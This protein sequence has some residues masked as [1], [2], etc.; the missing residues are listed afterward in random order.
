VTLLFTDIEGSTPLVRSLGG[1]YAD[2]LADHHRLLRDAFAAH[3]GY[4]VDTQ[5]DAFFVAFARASDAIDAATMA[6]Q[7][8]AAHHWPAGGIVRVRM[9]LH[10]GQPQ[11]TDGRYVGLDVHR[12]ARIAAA[13]HGG[14]VL[15]S[16]A[17]AALVR[18]TLDES[19]SLQNLGEH[20]FKHFERPEAVFQLVISGLPSE[21]PA[22]RGI[23]SLT[24]DHATPGN[25]HVTALVGRN[26]EQELLLGKLTQAVGGHGGLV[27]L[28]GEPGIGKTRLVEALG[29]EARKRSVQVLWGRCWES[30]GAPPFWPWVEILRGVVHSR[31]PLVFRAELGTGGPLIT[32]LVPEIGMQLPDQPPTPH[33]SAGEDRFRL[34]DAVTTLLQNV[35]RSQPL[36]VALDDLHWADTSSLLLLQFLA[37]RLGEA[38]ILV[39][40]TH[41]DAEVDTEHSLKEVLPALR[42]ERTFESIALTGLDI[43]AVGALITGSTNEPATIGTGLTEALWRQTNG[44]P[45]F[46]LEELRFLLE[47]GRLPAAAADRGSWSITSLGLPEG[48][49]D[50]IRQRLARLSEATADLLGIAA[51]IG[52][53]FEAAPLEWSSGAGERAVD[54]ALDEAEATRILEILPTELGRYRFAH[55]LF[56]EALYAELPARRRIRLHRRVGESLERQYARDPEAHL[57][58][59]AYHFVQALPTGTA[60][61]A[62]AYSERAAE[63][64]MESYAFE[65]A[66]R[67]FEQALRVQDVLDAADKTKRC[68]LV[69]ALGGALLASNEPRPVFDRIAPE[70]LE[71]ADAIGERGRATRSCLLALSGLLRYG[72]IPIT[73]TRP[74]RHWVEL[75]DR[76]AVNGTV[77]R[78]RVDL[79]SALVAVASGQVDRAVDLIRRSYELALGLAEP[80]VLALA[81]MRMLNMIYIAPPGR[82]EEVELRKIADQFLTSAPVGGVSV[83]S[84][85]LEALANAYRELGD[86]ERFHTALEQLAQLSER[87]KAPVAVNHVKGNKM[88]SALVAGDLEGAAATAARLRGSP[89]APSLPAMVETAVVFG[90]RT[91]LHLGRIE[92]L[93]ELVPMGRQLVDAD[94]GL[95]QSAMIAR[96]RLALLSALRGDR[97][98]AQQRLDQM[99]ADLLK[100]R[101]QPAA[102]V[103]LTLLETALEVQ[104]REAVKALAERLAPDAWRASVGEALT[105]AAR[106][107]GA[108]AAFLGEQDQARAYYEEALEV[109]GRLRFRPELALTH[110]QLAEL[111]LDEPRGHDEAMRHLNFAIA[112]FRDM[113]MQPSLERALRH[114]DVLKA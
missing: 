8:L 67:H 23:H 113:K 104:D 24:E 33:V 99:V 94:E 29:E 102:P 54:E 15:L 52:R 55:A 17:T 58:E 26:R 75:A 90:F 86:Y 6:Q 38:R 76:Y 64:A 32:G 19:V 4:E 109:C 28:G 37:Q 87:T 39:V 89:E 46:V 30:E 79:A 47:Q 70:A 107:L 59:L 93:I 82:V 3:H 66:V 65:E 108:A 43:D 18:E 106:H 61:K 98:E 105:S 2:V 111:L 49:R 63:H 74:F 95:G 35:S 10:T 20:A 13:A 68:D 80:S 42:R 96:S 14:Q 103:I 78:V 50:V 60:E 9:G 101:S 22:L 21:F 84:G 62:L 57:S 83:T 100:G 97:A 41:R 27:L 56:R 31:E 88:V 112:E 69:L 44:N 1:G 72:E 53:E 25:G 85:L 34:F 11:Q 77:D 92:E 5:G 114:K 48:L 40:G 73:E 16:Q 12:A 36:L 51:V 71:L 45:L 110:L 7:S 81:A 91:L